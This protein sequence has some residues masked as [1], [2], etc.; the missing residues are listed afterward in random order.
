MRFQ[1]KFIGALLLVVLLTTNGRGADNDDL[2]NEMHLGMNQDDWPRVLRA[3]DAGAKPKD[4]VDEQVFAF[5]AFGMRV[6]VRRDG[7]AARLCG[8]QEFFPRFEIVG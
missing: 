5:G 2:L 6:E 4:D 7:D 3:L 1:S 8:G